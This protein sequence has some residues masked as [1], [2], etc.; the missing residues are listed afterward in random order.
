MD[1][2]VAAGIMIAACLALAVFGT[3]RWTAT[4]PDRNDGFGA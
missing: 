1:I 3:L 4:P 2:L